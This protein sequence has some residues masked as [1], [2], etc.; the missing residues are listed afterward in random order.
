MTVRSGLLDTSVFI[1]HESGRGIDSTAL[2]EATAVSVVT[3]A[4]L[5]VGVLAAR[6]TAIRSRRLTTLQIASSVAAMPI[7]PEVAGAWAMLRVR[8]QEAGRRANAN[9]LW[10]AATALVGD[11]DIVTQDADYDAIEAVG[12]PRVIL[13]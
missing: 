13:V 6:S 10:I 4:E 3:L 8:L 5:Q 7:T 12:G 11:L 2:P 1:A 9:D